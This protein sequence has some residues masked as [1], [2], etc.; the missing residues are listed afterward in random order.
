MARP[1]IDL[2]D[3]DPRDLDVRAAAAGLQDAAR[4]AASQTSRA[5]RPVVA[6]VV[7]AVMALPLL[8][9]R[10]GSA[11]GDASVRLGGL[12]ATL[13]TWL[14]KG[15]ERARDAVDRARA[16]D[17]RELSF[18]PPHVRTRSQVRR[19]R[20]RRLGRYALVAGV[21]AGIGAGAAALARRRRE[22]ADLAEEARWADPA[23]DPHA[24]GGTG[25]TGVPATSGTAGPQ[26]GEIVDVAAA[27]R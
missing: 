20:G 26:D 4:G 15:S 19:E 13:S 23:A 14:T 22:E 9:G 7:H 5:M 25:A 21:A 11:V 27:E 16:I 2:R 6:Q 17:V 3:L 1:E 10:L 18:E 24:E 8:V 12:V